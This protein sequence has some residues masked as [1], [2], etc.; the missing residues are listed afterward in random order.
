MKNTNLFYDVD[1][2]MQNLLD[3]KISYFLEKE[4]IPISAIYEDE[5]MLKKIIK[6]LY[7]EEIKVTRKDIMQKFGI[8]KNLF[9][10]LI[11]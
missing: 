4:K 5:K 10:E 9:Y 11:K 8:Y 1:A 3:N 6:Y 2:N 7:N